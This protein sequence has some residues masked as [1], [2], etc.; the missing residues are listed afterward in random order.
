MSQYQ[1]Q[2]HLPNSQRIPWGDHTMKYGE[3]LKKLIIFTNTKIMV[4]ANETGYDISYI[5]KW[6]NK[7]ILPTTRTISVINKKLSK[8][9]ANEIMTQDRLDD[10]F[11]SFSDVIENTETNE[12][13]TFA[14]LAASIE[15]ALSSCYRSPAPRKA[16][17]P[18]C[19]SHP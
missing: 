1:K 4:I 7:G 18:N 3:L 2:K 19:R 10:F 5:S 11:I 15:S 9:F 16:Y 6:C 14:F 8:V 13:D 17:H 12:D